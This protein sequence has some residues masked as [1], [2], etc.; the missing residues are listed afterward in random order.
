MER[1]RE[2]FD[3]V[4]AMTRVCVTHTEVRNDLE[5]ICRLRPDAVQVSCRAA[6]PEH[7]R[8]RV[9]RMIQPGEE[10]PTGSDALFVD[11]SR[12]RGRL[13]DQRYA[14]DV[15]RSAGVPVFLAGGLTPDNVAAAVLAVRP[16]GV[17]VASGVEYAPGRKDPEKV[18]SFVEHAKGVI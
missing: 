7:C 9:F 2:I 1:A 12:G 4:P 13:Y 6:V 18:R 10:I 5:A 8:S 15:I 3:A 16:Y 14:A 11:G 17:D